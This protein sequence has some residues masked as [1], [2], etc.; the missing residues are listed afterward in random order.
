MITQ[1]VDIMP[2]RRNLHEG[3]SCGPCQLCGDMKCQ[4]YAHPI[5]WKQELKQ[6]LVEVQGGDV[7]I[8]GC[9][10]RNC[11]KDLKKGIGN[12]EY[13]YRW[14][15]PKEKKECIVPDCANKKQSGITTNICTLAEACS[16]L[17]FDAATDTDIIL[18]NAHYRQ[19]HRLIHAKDN[20]YTDKCKCYTCG[21][22]I[23]VSTVRH[24][25]DPCA[26][27]NYYCTILGMSV[28]INKEDKICK[29]CYNVQ[30]AILKECTEIS[31]DEELKYLLCTY[32]IED[33]YEDY[34]KLSIRQVVD[35]LG[36][37]LLKKEAVLFTE[38]YKKFL[39]IA[40]NISGK[41]ESDIQSTMPKRCLISKLI[42]TFGKHMVCQC[43]QLSCGL[44]LYRRGV[45]LAYS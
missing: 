27:T 26:I 8:K 6:G 35:M 5:Y 1:K 41:C 18:C 24:S 12:T 37:V 34:I 14:Q 22:T 45:D 20:M 39:S 13:I 23:K 11:E 31:F 2:K 17:N 29:S 25:P 30:L 16:M 33:D 4:Y 15:Q 42:T 43:K 36:E 21:A 40:T 3:K 28:S 38:V 44:L 32:I 7:D 19:L 9:I 10:C